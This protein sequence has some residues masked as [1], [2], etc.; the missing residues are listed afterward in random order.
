[1]LT[2]SSP[3]IRLEGRLI[4][5]KTGMNLP[6]KL[7]LARIILIFIFLVL[8]NAH[9][10]S[11]FSAEAVKIIYI[12]AYALAIIAGVTDFLD[13]YLA[14]KYNQVTEFGKLMDPLAD[15]IFVTATMLVLLEVQLVPAWIAVIVISREFLVTGLRLLAAQKGEVISADRWGKTKTALQMLMLLIAGSSWINLFDLKNACLWGIKLWPVW[16]VFLWAVVLI[17]IISGLGYF[18]RHRSLFLET[19]D[20]VSAE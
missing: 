8:A 11:V 3:N 1:M 10:N 13:G 18:V 16:N 9:E 6:N 5:K 19:S 17:T 7:T 14:R 2:A 20:D 12:I 15:K 4:L